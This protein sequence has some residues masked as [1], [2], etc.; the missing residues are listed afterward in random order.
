MVVLVVLAV[1]VL[2]VLVLVVLVVLVL[3][4]LVVLVL[5]VL[6]VLVVLVVVGAGASKMLPRMATGGRCRFGATSLSRRASSTLDSSNNGR[7]RILNND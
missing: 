7:N 1:P 4:V 5:V 3:V 2:H 6:A